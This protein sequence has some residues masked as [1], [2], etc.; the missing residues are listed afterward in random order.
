MEL[1][2][3]VAPVCRAWE[4]FLS[5]LFMSPVQLVGCA[6]EG[7]HR[8][9]DLAAVCVTS[10]RCCSYVAVGRLMKCSRLVM[11]PAANGVASSS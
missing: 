3:V 8:W 7:I 10:T 1:A 2:T 6:A 9:D 11:G 5:G 4:T